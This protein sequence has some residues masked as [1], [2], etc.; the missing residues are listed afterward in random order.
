M[1]HQCHLCEKSFLKKGF[2]TK[3]LKSHSQP[4]PFICDTEGCD[5]TFVSTRGLEKH[6]KTVHEGEE[7]MLH[8]CAFCQKGFITRSEMESHAETHVS[9]YKMYACR[10]CGK[11]FVKKF[12]MKIAVQACQDQPVD[13][14]PYC[15]KGINPN[16]YKDN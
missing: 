8:L 7:F 15:N 1:K 6:V 16:A 5:K 2:L 12:A 9:D 3:H 13:P 10:Y 14:C 11:T 4:R